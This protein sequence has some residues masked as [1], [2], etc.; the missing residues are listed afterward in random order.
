MFRID[1]GSHRYVI[2]H[3]IGGIAGNHRVQ[4]WQ[5]LFE[6]FCFLSHDTAPKNKI[7]SSQN[8]GNLGGIFYSQD[9][10]RAGISAAIFLFRHGFS[11]LLRRISLAQHSKLKP[12]MPF[13]KCYQPCP[14]SPVPPIIPILIFF[15]AYHSC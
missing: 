13:Q 9:L 7:T 12:G 5:I 6:H 10:S 4:F 11:K 3:P 2:C 15:I 14:T 8:L 1:S